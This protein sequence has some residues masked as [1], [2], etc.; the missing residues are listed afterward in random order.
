[1]SEIGGI[2]FAVMGLAF[3][4]LFGGIGSALGVSIAGQSAA[5]VVSEDPAKFGRV[6]ILQLLPGTQ[7]I[8]GLVIALLAMSQVGILGGSADMSVT[9]GLYYFAACLPVGF[10]GLASG[11]YQGKASVAAINLFNKRPEQFGKAMLFP[12]M[13][14]TYAIFGMVV[15]LLAVLF[16]SN[17]G[18]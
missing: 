15:S 17:L 6:L 8:Y 18:L 10:T 1:M 2:V 11:I 9:E 3:A 7:G 4:A 5:G 12:I 13:V 14:E 16:V